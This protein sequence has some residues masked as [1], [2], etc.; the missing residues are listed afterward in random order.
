MRC[1]SARRRC[2]QCAQNHLKRLATLLDEAR[3][4][5]RLAAGEHAHVARCSPPLEL[6]ALGGLLRRG[7]GATPGLDAGLGLSLRVQHGWGRAPGQQVQG[8]CKQ[9]RGRESGQSARQGVWS[10]R[11]AEVNCSACY[12]CKRAQGVRLAEVSS[13][14][15]CWEWRTTNHARADHEAGDG[16]PEERV[17]RRRR[18]RRFSVCMAKRA[19]MPQHIGSLGWS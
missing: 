6:S 10:M 11:S 7:D 13:A 14:I 8:A 2:S 17:S 3:I 4:G 18:H 9:R 19:G 5:D 15:D 12:R 1:V 16:V